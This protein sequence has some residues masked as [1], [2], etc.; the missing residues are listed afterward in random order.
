MRKITYN[1]A[2]QAVDLVHNDNGAAGARVG[3]AYG[4]NRERI[5]RLD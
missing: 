5:R 1:A 4:P 3:F 2:D